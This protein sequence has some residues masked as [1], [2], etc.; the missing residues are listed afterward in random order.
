MIFGLQ[1]SD[2][3]PERWTPLEAVTVLKC[4]DENGKAVFC[5]RRT[6]TLTDMECYALLSITAQSQKEDILD[7]FEDR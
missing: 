1:T 2:P 4:V 6:A 3:L 7:H 5:V